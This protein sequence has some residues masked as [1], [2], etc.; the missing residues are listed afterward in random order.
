MLDSLQLIGDRLDQRQQRRVD[1]DDFVLGV[2]DDVFELLMRQA[3]IQGVDD[4]AGAGDAEVEF[5]M[6]IIVPGEGTHAVARLDAQCLQGIA[7][8][9]HPPVQISIAV[10]M[11]A[12]VGQPGF[13]RLPRA[14]AIGMLDDCIQRQGI[15]HHQTAQHNRPP[16]R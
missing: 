9:L 1:E 14:H 10:F 16:A 7:Q 3:D 8:A 6:L 4:G 13:D 5:Q 12:A 2:V 11:P 15:L